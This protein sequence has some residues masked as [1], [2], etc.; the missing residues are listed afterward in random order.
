MG[1]AGM[2][3]GFHGCDQGVAERILAGKAHVSVSENSHDWLGTGAYFWENSPLRALQW[4][5]LVHKHPQHF[6]HRIRKPA[7][8]G[9][10]IETGNSLDLTQSESL[11]FL[12][13]AWKS[14][15]DACQTSGAPLPANEPGFSGDLDLVKRHLDCAVI[16][17][18]HVAREARGFRPYDTVRGAFP[19]GSP[20]F[21][22][23]RIMEQTH[24]QI[25]V[26][27][28]RRSIR[29]YF[30]PLPQEERRAA[31]KR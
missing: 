31:R 13:E 28:P 15:K 21:E 1:A 7:V 6:Q 19:E 24:V 9:A 3:L 30:R 20:L 26:R 27:Q 12:K 16:N 23:S 5:E 10:I 22:G 17:I 18:A 2:V 11:A 4:A 29:G 25:C 8:V 14:L